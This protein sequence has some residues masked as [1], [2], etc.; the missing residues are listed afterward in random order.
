M[1]LPLHVKILIGAILGAGAGGAAYLIWKDNPVTA[2]INEAANLKWVI[3]YIAKPIG[4]VFL[5]LLFMLV[6]PLMFSALV[7]GVSEYKDLRKLGAVGIK[8][9]TYTVIVSMIAVFIG[10][11]LVNLIRPGDGIPDEVRTRLLAEATP[12]KTAASTSVKT[13][14]DLIV[15]IVPRNP[16]KA[17]ADGDYLAWMF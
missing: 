4:D 3:T 9:L 11:S 2:D 8:T 7:L 12:E 15:G 10:I 14:M 1:R 17:A 6:L 16:I 13:G 5:N